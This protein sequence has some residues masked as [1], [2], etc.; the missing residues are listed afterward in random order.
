MLE[1]FVQY[2]ISFDRTHLIPISSKCFTLTSS[3]NSTRA[4]GLRGEG[5]E[6]GE[7][8]TSDVGAVPFQGWNTGISRWIVVSRADGREQT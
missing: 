6:V 4:Q 1:N 8:G 2:T 5:F 7:V 3:T